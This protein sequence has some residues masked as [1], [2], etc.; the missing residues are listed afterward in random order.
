VPAAAGENTITAMFWMNESLQGEDP[1]TPNEYPLSKGQ[2]K[3]GKSNTLMHQ[4][5]NVDLARKFVN[6]LKLTL[7]H[8]F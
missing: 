3:Q 1:T 5:L 7:I 8:I 2:V 6:F 4:R